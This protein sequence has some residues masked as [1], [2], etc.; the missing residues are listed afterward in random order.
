MANSLDI[1][2][3][4]NDLQVRDGDLTIG[5]SDE[6][7]VADTI[8]AFPGWWK[9]YPADG[10]GV[11]AYLNSAGQEQALSRAIKLNLTSDGYIVNNPSI[12]TDADGILTVNPN[13]SRP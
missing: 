9:E 13:A 7:H 11:F 8:N 1:A 12:V 5:E 2:L 4:Q 6:Q 10:V 3:Y